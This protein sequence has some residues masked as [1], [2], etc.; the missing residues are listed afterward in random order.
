MPAI[1]SDVLSAAHFIMRHLYRPVELD[2]GARFFAVA[3]TEHTFGG[4]DWLWA[5][6]NAKVLEFVSRP[7]IWRLYPDQPLEMLRFVEA[8]CHGPFIFRRVAAPRLDRVEGTGP[9]GRF[10]HS[11][12]HIRA[13][14]PNG[15]VT[16]GVRFHDGRTADNLLLTG[17]NVEFTHKRRRVRIN[18]KG[19]LTDIAAEQKG[20]RLTLR[21]SGD[22]VFSALW[23][24][25][26]LGRITY[27]Y[28]IDARSMLI[29]VEATLEVDARAAVSDVVL[30]IGHD[31]L[32]H[33]YNGVRYDTL[34]AKLAG[35]NTKFVAAD[36]TRLI[37]PAAGASYYEIAQAE[38][39]GFALA[40]HTVPREPAR[41]AEFD[42]RVAEPGKL[43]LVRARY[44]F[45]GSCRGATLKVGED[46]LLTSGGFYDRVDDYAELMQHALKAGAQPSVFDYSVSYDYGAEINAFAKCFAAAE[47]EDFAGRG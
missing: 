13:D 21:L 42:I 37:L 17:N 23:R 9:V 2:N 1:P 14:L 32:S 22:L 8:M 44:R 25:I 18:P 6:D 38:I 43:H 29:G 4:D 36:K 28:T 35:G 34:A 33:G 24:K 26:R 41:L 19:A 31:Q 7:D 10:E 39:A 30:S 16:A 3:E 47:H 12:M 15:L 45:D 46:K 27:V 11:L 40:V 5:D 20:D